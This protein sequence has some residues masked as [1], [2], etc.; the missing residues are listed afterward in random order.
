MRPLPDL[1]QVRHHRRVRAAAASPAGGRA[2]T[3]P[4]RRRARLGPRGRTAHRHRPPPHRPAHRPRRD[5]RPPHPRDRT[6]TL[7]VCRLS[8]P[9][10]DFDGLTPLNEWL[11]G[12]AAADEVTPGPIGAWLPPNARDLR[13][14]EPEPDTI[15]TDIDPAEPAF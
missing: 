5:H 10:D 11:P 1:R 4:G 8:E 6:T 7:H 2:T 13:L 12:H 15:P 3:R 14:D 9:I